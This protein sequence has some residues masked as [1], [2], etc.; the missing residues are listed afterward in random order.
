M[1]EAAGRVND[2]TL[3][4]LCDRTVR[5]VRRGLPFVESMYLR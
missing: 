3:A 1:E 5:K 4:D 2:D